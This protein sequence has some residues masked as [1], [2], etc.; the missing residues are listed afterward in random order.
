MVQ[1]DNKSVV[2]DSASR[3]KRDASGYVER[4]TKAIRGGVLVV[5]YGSMDKINAFIEVGKDGLVAVCTKSN[6]YH[7]MILGC[8]DSVDEAMEDF[9]ECRD[10][11]KQMEEESGRTFPDLEFEFAYDTES[12]LRYYGNILTLTGLQKI[13]GVH[14]KQLSHYATGQSRP[15]AKTVRRI[16]EGISRFA[17]TL[18]QVRLV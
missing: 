10:E 18:K 16:Q 17:D 15:T 8:G 9:Y 5:N 13:T 12:F 1:P 11:L 6:K 2:S 4:N 7:Y 3:S 14:H